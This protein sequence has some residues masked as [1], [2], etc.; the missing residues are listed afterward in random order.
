MSGLGSGDVQRRNQRRAASRAEPVCQPAPGAAARRKDLIALTEPELHELADTALGVHGDY[1]PT[2]RAM[3]LFAGYVGLR[4]GELF[5]L[6]RTDI[7]GDEVVIR[8]SLDGTGK[9]R[10]PKNNKERVVI[11]PPPARVAL[12][13]VM[14]RLDVPWLFVSKRGM[15]LRETSLTYCWHPVR[16]AFGRPTIDF[17]ELRHFCATHLLELGLSPADVAI[18][19][20]HTDGGALAMSTYGHPSEDA[21][22]ERLKRAFAN[23]VAPLR[24]GA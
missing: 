6:E 12:G 23:N 18:Q 16:A 1:G 13:D 7:R 20:G 2:F 8:Q 10:L 22:R 14:P 4:P 15:Q 19:L 11:L 3:I 17:Y 9:L 21:A 24:G 5:A